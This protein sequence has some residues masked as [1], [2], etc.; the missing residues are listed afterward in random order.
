MDVHCSTCG[1]PW[2]VFHLREDEIFDADLTAE[3][4]A[5][6]QSL[7]PAQK[8]NERY[9]AKFHANGWKFGKSVINVIRC[10]FCPKDAQP[11]PET[12]AI[13]A[14]LEDL[15]MDDEDALAVTFEDHHL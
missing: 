8:L 4:A 1:E 15:L 6:W 10:P 2:D 9:R 13:K 11:N 7:P 3:E 14:A 12:V 5:A